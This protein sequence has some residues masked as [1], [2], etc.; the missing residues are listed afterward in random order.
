MCAFQ[1]IIPQIISI[2]QTIHRGTLFCKYLGG[3]SLKK[4]FVPKRWEA[5][6][7]VSLLYMADNS[8]LSVR[9]MYRCQIQSSGRKRYRSPVQSCFSLWP[10]SLCYLWGACTYASYEAQA[11][12]G[13][14]HQSRVTCFYGRH[15]FVICEK[16]ADMH[17]SYLQ[18]E[19][20]FKCCNICTH[21]T[22]INKGI[23]KQRTYYFF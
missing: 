17:P 7:L 9:R 20:M 8:L 4:L 23:L 6:R 12:G 2:N 10:T 15:I 13:T 19:T 21:T 16:D 3:P 5:Y 14:G 1:I 22:Y 11:E 18:I